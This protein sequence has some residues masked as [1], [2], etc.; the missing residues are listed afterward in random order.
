MKLKALM[1]TRKTSCFLEPPTDSRKRDAAPFPTLSPYRNIISEK[2]RR[3]YTAITIYKSSSTNHMKYKEK[4][5][6]K[7]THRWSWRLKVFPQTLHAYLRSELCV[8]LCFANALELLNSL[9]QTEHSMPESNPTVTGLNFDGRPFFFGWFTSKCSD[10]PDEPEWS[11]R[12]ATAELELSFK[13]EPATSTRLCKQFI[14]YSCN[15]ND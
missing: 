15:L 6:I 4:W 13:H 5:N 11:V 12:P 14:Y 10:P 1:Q 9:W 8:N 2:Y 3:S 7:K